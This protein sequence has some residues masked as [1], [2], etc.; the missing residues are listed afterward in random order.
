MSQPSL[1]GYA[2][3]TFNVTDKNLLNEMEKKIKTTISI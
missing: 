2:T 3:S 1:L